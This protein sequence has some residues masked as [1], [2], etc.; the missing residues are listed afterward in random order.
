MVIGFLL[1]VVAIPVVFLAMRVI[2]RKPVP[3]P[4]PASAGAFEEVG[5]YNRPVRTRPRRSG[6]VRFSAPPVTI[7]TIPPAGLVPPIDRG[8]LAALASQRPVTVPRPQQ[9]AR[10]SVP[11]SYAPVGSDL[12]DAET[13]SNRQDAGD[14]MVTR[15]A[16]L[17]DHYARRR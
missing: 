10:G 4:L 6:P 2:E 7:E 11:P 9:L 5:T 1:M 14:N 16:L 12:D 8:V 3:P 15:E 13:L 17:R